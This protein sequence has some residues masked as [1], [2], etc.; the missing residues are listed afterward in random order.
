MVATR[1]RINE[2]IVTR[3]RPTDTKSREFW[4]ANRLIAAAENLN[5]APP[6]NRH[7]SGG[8][9]LDGCTES[10]ADGGPIGKSLRSILKASCY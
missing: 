5:H 6:V 1:K 7:L 9:S 8:L 3:R 4:Y 10:V 2:A